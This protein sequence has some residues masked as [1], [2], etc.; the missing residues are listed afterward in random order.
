MKENLAHQG[1][2]PTIN[3]QSVILEAINRVLVNNTDHRLPVESDKILESICHHIITIDEE[4]QIAL[5]AIKGK[6]NPKH[7]LEFS[8][9][10]TKFDNDEARILGWIDLENSM[11]TDA[12]GKALNLEQLQN[13]NDCIKQFPER[14]YSPSDSPSA[15]E[16]STRESMP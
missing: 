2:M 9:S 5:I 3:E 4:D 10:S 14:S 15:P 12:Y 13:L 16:D 8:L 7:I 1:E 6:H 11:I